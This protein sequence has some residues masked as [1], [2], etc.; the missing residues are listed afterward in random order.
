[1]SG[2]TR[3]SSGP[4][5]RLGRRKGR[6]P[7]D[8]EFVRQLGQILGAKG[9][10]VEPALT[11]DGHGRVAF[12]VVTNCDPY[13]YAGRLPVHATP[14]ARFELG[15]D[16]VG[17]RALGRA[18]LARLG[19]SLLAHPT[20]QGSADYLYLHDLDRI[21]IACDRPTP[22]QVDGED[23]G[24]VTELALESERDALTVLV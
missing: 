9:W 6:R 8:V 21:E 15:I 23:I 5:T 4:S 20:H 7:S 19:W 22:L 18:G 1:M 12:A 3:S 10:R 24:D 2:S 14:E 16:L 13:T 17:P 11:V